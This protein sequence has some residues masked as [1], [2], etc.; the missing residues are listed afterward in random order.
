M[1][2]YLTTGGGFWPIYTTAFLI[3]GAFLGAVVYLLL[4]VEKLHIENRSQ[5]MDT[6][7]VL[8]AARAYVGMHCTDAP[9]GPV[10]LADALEEL[11]W[12]GYVRE[13]DHWS[14]RL[15]HG[16]DSC[17]GAHV[18][19]T[20]EATRSLR[21]ALRGKCARWNAA[22]AELLIR[23]TVISIAREGYQLRWDDNITC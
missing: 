12:Y 18:L 19:Y 9:A 23:P 5:R 11:G 3:F 6:G 17:T 22:G 13:P 7:A 10:G 16:P 21:K 14:V 2:S 20:G 1:K 15:I 8:S 4:G